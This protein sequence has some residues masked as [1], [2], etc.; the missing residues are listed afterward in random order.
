MLKPDRSK[1]PEHVDGKPVIDLDSEKFVKV[2]HGPQHPGITGNMSLELTLSGDEVVDCK[3]HVGY[4]HRG[5]EKLIERRTFIQS[6]PI[7]CRIAVPEPAFNEYN[8]AAG[9]EEL[10]GI[11]IPEKAKWI[12]TLNLEM[13]RL[14]SYLMWIGGMAGSLGHGTIGQWCVV[15]RD[16][17]LDLFEEMTGGRV[18]HMFMIPGGVRNNLPEGFENRAFETFDKIE[19]ILETI[20]TVMMNNI[21]FKQRTVGLGLITPDMVDQYGIVGPNI[22]AMGIK[23]D[24]RIDEPYAAYGNLKMDYQTETASDAYARCSV[25]MKETVQAIDL[26]RQVLKGMPK[27]GPFHTQTP[28]V[29]NWK[30]KPGQTYIKSECTRGEYGFFMVTDGSEYLR[31]IHVRGP[32]Y[33]HAVSLMEDMAVNVNVSDIAGLMVSLHTYP[34]EVER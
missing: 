21:V 32:S 2:W 6:F 31:R 15:H 20:D 23:R 12:R 25:R 9:I 17:V 34:P 11:E 24:L 29:M 10:S 4:L 16:Y 27:D 8:F 26:C 33:S 19:K 14:A 1:Y 7:V 5:F 18:Y 3:T 22:R 30:I 28:N 13:M